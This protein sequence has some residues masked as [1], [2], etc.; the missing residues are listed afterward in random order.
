MPKMKNALTAKT[1][2]RHILYQ[3][4]VQNVEAEIDFVDEQFRKRRGRHARRLREDFCGTANTS[5]EWVR[6]RP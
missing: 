6:R 5:C 2:D 1:A 4:S 3:E